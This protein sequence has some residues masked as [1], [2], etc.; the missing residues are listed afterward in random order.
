[1]TDNEID[2]DNMTLTIK[3]IYREIVNIFG[4][5]VQ[6]YISS[7][8]F[9]V[10]IVYHVYFDVFLLKFRYLPMLKVPGYLPMLKVPGLIRQT[11]I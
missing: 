7:L 4:M 11:R 1:M 3:F 6:V 5:T 2:P 8:A 10:Y 9:T